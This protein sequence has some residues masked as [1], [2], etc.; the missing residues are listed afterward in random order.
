MRFDIKLRLVY[1]VILL[2]FLLGPCQSCSNKKKADV[3]ASSDEPELN[4]GVPSATDIE[5]IISDAP[6]S[7]TPSPKQF[8][9]TTSLG[10]FDHISRD[11]QTIMISI[12]QNC[13][14]NDY[15]F[16]DHDDCTPNPC[17]N[18]GICE[19][20]ASDYK[21]ACISGWEGKN[22]DLSKIFVNR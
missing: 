7:N 2:G 3:R 13:L 19:D 1:Q 18:S 8:R 12:Q 17:Q 6:E 4:T 9:N 10:K 22:C 5:K 16:A 20:L 14:I 15:V 21:C 11:T